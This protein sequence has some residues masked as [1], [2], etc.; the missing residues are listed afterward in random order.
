VGA[1]PIGLAPL[2]GS[3]RFDFPDGIGELSRGYLGAGDYR[4]SRYWRK[5]EQTTGRLPTKLPILSL[6][7]PAR[8]FESAIAWALKAPM[9][10]VQRGTEFLVLRRASA[11]P[12]S[13][14][15]REETPIHAPAS[16]SLLWPE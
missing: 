4:Q 15:M 5:P 16:S 13:H 11:Y 7:R 14:R 12:K 9:E 2:T 3:K 10:T 6:R 8:T 1:R